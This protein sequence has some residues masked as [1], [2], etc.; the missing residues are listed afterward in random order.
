LLEEVFFLCHSPLWGQYQVIFSSLRLVG[1][2]TRL[3]LALLARLVARV[4]V[5]FSCCRLPTWRPLCCLL[6]DFVS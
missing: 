4:A 3:A 1:G 5:F 2:G 6:G